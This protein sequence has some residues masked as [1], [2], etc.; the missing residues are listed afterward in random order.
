MR[1]VI[2]IGSNLITEKNHLLNEDFIANMVLQISNLHK[3]GHDIVLVSSGAVAA[4]R[5]EITLKK[6][7]KNIPYR[8]A[9][10]AVGQSV[11]M[12]TYRT[13]FGKK[14]ITI[15][16]ALLIKSDFINRHRFLNTRNT[17]NLLLSQKVVSIVNENDVT[18]YDEIQRGDNDN[19]S[20]KVASM[21]NADYLII[22]TTTD[23]LMTAPPGT[24]GAKLI[25]IVEQITPG[26]KKMAKGPQDSNSKGGMI[27][28]L[29]AADYAQKSGC[30]VLIA[31]GNMPNV[32]EKALEKEKP[33]TFF[34]E[35]SKKNISKK[36]WIQ[37]NID[38]NGKIIIDDGAKRALLGK[39]C[40]L[41]PSGIIGV[42]GNFKRG[43]IIRVY[44]QNGNEIGFG[45][46]NYD[47][48][49]INKIKK[50]NSSEISSI[51]GYIFEDEIIHR[52]NF[53]Y[54]ALK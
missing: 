54:I 15:G 9:L 13:F 43:T 5:G 31:N 20:A 40:S 42:K 23:G 8:Q 3:N 25:K 17:L 16:Q 52:D 1:I 18:V 37:T 22:L 30:N 6:E 7:S 24:P 36:K 35:L 29:E 48:K 47:S 33:G 14:K 28:K 21:I 45:Q 32:L 44:D 12:H 41:L 19:L 2:K 11:L 49:D 4:G 38:K 34:P 53:T 46:V 39:G 50:H 26:I 51:L 27:T 10:S